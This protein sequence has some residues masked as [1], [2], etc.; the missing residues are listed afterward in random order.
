M[1]ERACL[2]C[3]ETDRD[4]HTD[5]NHQ[6]SEDGE[7]RPVDRSTPRRQNNP[8]PTVIVAGAIDMPLR[9]LLLDKGL[10][11]SEDFAALLDSAESSLGRDRGHRETPGT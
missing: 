2:I 4:R 9:K 11:T 10:L 5:R 6:F 7:L 1:I 3:G 8:Q